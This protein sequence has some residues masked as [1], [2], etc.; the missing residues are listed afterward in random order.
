V[1]DVRTVDELERALK[2]AHPEP[3]QPARLAEI[4]T[5]GRRRR[6]ARLAGV[7]VGSAA[8]VVAACVGA[9]AVTG[10]TADR[11][12][13]SPPV[14]HEPPHEMSDIAKR[15]LAEIP[16]A[17][18]VSSWQVV[19]PMPAGARAS[20]GAEQD[21]PTDHVEAG[22]V[23]LDTRWYTGVTTFR[24]KDFPAWLYD[25]IADYEQNVLGDESNGYPVGSTDIGVLVDAGP[26]RLACMTPL[27]QWG[28]TEDAGATGCFPAMLSGDDAH[29]QYRWGMGTDDF[30]QPGKDLELFDTETYTS[31]SPRMVWVGGTDGTD[32]ATVD[33][34]TTDGQTVSATV[35]P[36]SL[37]PG[38]TM[39][40]GVVDGDLATAIT[41]DS[42]GNVLEE[43]RLE[44]CSDPVD[45]EVR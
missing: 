15:A 27:P 30:L 19:I 11:A 33:L 17:V 37:V 42:E 5:R 24:K 7:A 32:V 35:A 39:F 13:D 9:A 14:A 22:P 1:N 31:G 29:L 2:D 43:H 40:W 10:G 28:D 26:M 38:E 8:A 34:V 21:V 36:G 18:Q 3:L 41:R 16:G 44:P 6:R 23:D 4:R 25:G 20:N 12:D 45:C